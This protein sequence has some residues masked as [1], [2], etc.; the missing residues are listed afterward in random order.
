MAFFLT[1]MLL[2]SICKSYLAL[3]HGSECLVSRAFMATF[4]IRPRFEDW[5]GMNYLSASVL[6]HKIDRDRSRVL[7]N[8][9][10]STKYVYI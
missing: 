4:S 6:L 3:V 1:A 8:V 9:Y 10:T 7:K 2:S 5:T